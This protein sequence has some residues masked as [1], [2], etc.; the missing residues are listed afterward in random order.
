MN[1]LHTYAFQ[2]SYLQK[3]NYIDKYSFLKLDATLYTICINQ[4]II[5]HT[6]FEYC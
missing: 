6:F 1:A 2:I 3:M 5:I 4:T